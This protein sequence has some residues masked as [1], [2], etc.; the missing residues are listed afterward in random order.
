MSAAQNRLLTLPVRLIAQRKPILSELLE[1]PRPQFGSGRSIEKPTTWR[2]LGQSIQTVPRSSF[3]T[4]ARLRIRWDKMWGKDRI[5]KLLA[6]AKDAT[7]QEMSD[8]KLIDNFF[9][10]AVPK[11]EQAIFGFKAQESLMPLTPG[12]P[13]S[14]ADTL[15][16]NGESLVSQCKAGDDFIQTPAGFFRQRPGMSPNPSALRLCS[17][18]PN[19]KNEFAWPS[20]IAYAINQFIRGPGSLFFFDGKD[21]TNLFFPVQIWLA[22]RKNWN[23]SPDRTWGEVKP[24]VENAL[25]V[26]KAIHGF[27]FPTPGQAIGGIWM[28]L[29]K[30][31]LVKFVNIPRVHSKD[32]IEAFIVLDLLTRWERVITVMEKHFERRAKKQK[33]KMIV[34]IVAGVALGAML[35]FIAPA[36]L[37]TGVT[38]AMG[39]LEDIKKRKA[40]VGLQKA[41]AQFAKTDVAFSGKI[42]NVIGYLGTIAAEEA[43]Q[44]PPTPIEQEA[45][46]EPPEEK[47][48]I[49]Q[50]IKEVFK[51]NV[52]ARQQEVSTPPPAVPPPPMPI[53]AS[54]TPRVDLPTTRSEIPIF[55]SALP[56]EFRESPTVAAPTFSEEGERESGFPLGTILIAGVGT[57]ALGT[58]V[59]MILK[60]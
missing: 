50:Q 26:E 4:P 15:A 60:K 11:P 48:P 46:L 16:R 47:P 29:A 18:I 56:Q 32:D 31:D 39:G 19:A 13:S 20:G 5:D 28:D 33:R 54:I 40:A 44:K 23:I 38:L 25:N 21:H 36:I 1:R 57:L 3:N 45:K 55:D 8:V 27:P 35:T 42:Q 52:E 34:K 49:Q 9:G 7:V 17:F 59:A 51:Q 6:M 2:V 41:M 53:P 37:S 43:E 58:V 12:R 10:I 22:G 14:H 30:N 24:M